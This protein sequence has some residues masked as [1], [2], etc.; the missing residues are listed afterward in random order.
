[1]A[2]PHYQITAP[3]LT[4]AGDPSLTLKATGV[5]GRWGSGPMQ[6]VVRCFGVQFYGTG[7]RS[8]AGVIKFLKT[9]G[10]AILV[11]SAA[12]VITSMTVTAGD[13]REDGMV[14]NN[15]F[16]PAKIPGGYGIAAVV[17]TTVSGVGASGNAR[18]RAWAIIEP[19]PERLQNFSTGYFLSVTA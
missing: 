4:T 18:F 14:F 10:P 3:F 17:S 2:Y 8:G 6:H 7:N 19:S 16:T 1:M 5:K 15:S 12:N 9:C 11:T 13:L